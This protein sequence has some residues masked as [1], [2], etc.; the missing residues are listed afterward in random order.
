MLTHHTQIVFLRLW[1]NIHGYLG[2]SKRFVVAMPQQAWFLCSILLAISTYAKSLSDT[3]CMLFLPCLA[4]AFFLMTNIKSYCL[5]LA[6]I[7]L[8][9]LSLL[10]FFSSDL[11][12]ITYVFHMLTYLIMLCFTTFSWFLRTLPHPPP[13]PPKL[14]CLWDLLP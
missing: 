8:S 6:Y 12:F 7:S 4:N 1:K 9:F 14:L 5:N 11:N 2:N 3:A 10:L 13:A